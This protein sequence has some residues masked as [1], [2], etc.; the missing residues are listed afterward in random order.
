MI[1]M[2]ESVETLTDAQTPTP[3]ISYKLFS[4][5]KMSKF[6]S[7]NIAI[8]YESCL[9]EATQTYIRNMIVAYEMKTANKANQSCYLES[10]EITIMSTEMF[11]L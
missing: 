8:I 5:L 4:D 10:T 1:L 3:C 6:N 9:A 11:A 2:F 7:I